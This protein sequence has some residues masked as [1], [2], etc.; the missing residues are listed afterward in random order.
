MKPA[1]KYGILLSLYLAQSIPMSFFST[2]LPVIMRMEEYSLSSIGLIQLI[3]IPWIVK[4]LWGPIVDHNARDNMHYRKWI[5]GSEVFYAVVIVA[6]G[7][8]NLQSNFTTI[9]VLMIIAFVMSSIQD[10]GS[11]ALAVR[12][13]KKTERGLGNSMQSSGNFL[14]TLFGSGVLLFLYTIIGW[15]YLMFV[16][17]GIVLI[18]LI[19]VSRYREPRK[20]Q[21][22]NIKRNRIA[23]SNILGFFRQKRIGRRVTLL[24]I[25]YAGIIGILAMLKPYLVDLGYT[26][27]EIA[28]MTGIFGTGLGAG[29]AFLGGY[30]LRRLGNMKGLRLF[31]LY[32]CLA[33]LFM[34]FVAFGN[35]HIVL[36]YTGIALIWSAY[37]MSSVAIFTISMNTV[38]KG[39]EG[40][41]Y[42]LQIVL[43]HL[44][45]LMV[46][47]ISGRIGDWIGYSGLFLT[48]AVVG[49]IVT[50]SIG[51]LYF[52][53]E[54]VRQPDYVI[55]EQ[56]KKEEST[57]CK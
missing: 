27:K 4:F 16:L 3:K 17:S 49:L 9:I 53:P 40:T 44:S 52:D 19:P 23:F 31:A 35:T 1:Q 14:G 5:I 28:F 38:R 45:S 8:F 39:K 21:E 46:V 15:Q 22:F 42:T 6:I 2:V 32:G 41:D 12:I 13:L 48:E 56:I 36:V 57:L 20:Q 11:D 50:L 30:I 18:A 37:G 51:R 24:V 29:S 55:S 47:V 10:I 7:F 43:T 34:T 26:V 54:L 25:Y 33:A